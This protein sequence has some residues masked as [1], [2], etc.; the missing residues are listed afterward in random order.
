MKAWTCNLLI[1]GEHMLDFTS[2][3]APLPHL[4]TPT[5]L[6][7]QLELWF[8][9][10]SWWPFKG[11]RGQIFGL[12]LQHKYMIFFKSFERLFFHPKKSSPSYIQAIQVAEK[13]SR[14]YGPYPSNSAHLAL[15]RSFCSCVLAGDGFP[16]Q[17]RICRE[18]HGRTAAPK[19]QK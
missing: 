14:I 17:L 13:S 15:G 4:H 19:R 8:E 9:L 3:N 12:I 2:S 1:W 18:E 5:M 7:S 11:L 10:C 6:G 16:A